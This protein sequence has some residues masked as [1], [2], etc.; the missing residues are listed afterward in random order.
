MTSSY[1]R[2]DERPRHTSIATR[3]ASAIPQFSP[4]IP[5]VLPPLPSPPRDPDFLTGYTV[6]TH[7]VPAASPRESIFQERRHAGDFPSISPVIPSEKVKTKQDRAEWS[8]RMVE[9]LNR[10]RTGITEAMIRA[11]ST[12][13]PLDY[14]EEDAGPLLWNAINRY[15]RF[16]E[17]RDTRDVGLTVVIAH[18]NGMH[19]EVNPLAFS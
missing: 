13:S 9:A 1:P 16:Q 2:P 5:P 15:A 11:E 10:K 19:K 6:T 12:W 7:L 18:A 14:T 8:K 17:Q 4:S 3:D